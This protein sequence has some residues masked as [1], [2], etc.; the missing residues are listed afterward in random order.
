MRSPFV[1]P[2]F[3]HYAESLTPL[4][5]DTFPAP[6]HLGPLEP[7]EIAAAT[8]QDED[9][10]LGAWSLEAAARQLGTDGKTLLLLG[11]GGL[12]AGYLFND[13]WR[14]ARRRSRSGLRKLKGAF[15]AASSSASQSGT[16]AKAGT[17]VLG[18]VFIGGAYYLYREYRRTHG[19][20]A[21]GSHV[22]PAMHA[23]PPHPESQLKPSSGN[24]G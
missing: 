11:G 19:F 16:G 5:S 7:A 20:A 4:R 24:R 14:A 8:G 2:L 13:F 6:L 21:A 9:A 12:L 15:G 10:T 18:A 17:L 22:A 23:L 3:L 1:K